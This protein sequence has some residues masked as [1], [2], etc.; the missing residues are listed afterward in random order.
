M[1]L[2]VDAVGVK[3][4]VVAGRPDACVL[5]GEEATTWVAKRAVHVLCW[6]R[7][8]PE[9][10]QRAVATQVPAVAADHPGP[11]VPPAEVTARPPALMPLF[12]E[13]AIPAAIP[14]KSE[15]GVGPAEPPEVQR[16]PVAATSAVEPAVAQADSPARQA[17]SVVDPAAA[18]APLAQLRLPCAPGSRFAASAVVVDA[19]GL[20]LPDG[21]RHDLPQPFSH[22]GH[23]TELVTTLRLGTAVTDRWAEKGQ[24]WLTASAGAMFDLPTELP[25]SGEELRRVLGEASEVSPFVVDAIAQGWSVGGEKAAMTGGW[26]NVKHTSP[27][28][29]EAKALICYLPAID[30]EHAPLLITDDPTPATLARRLQMFAS[31]LGEPWHFSSQTTGFQLAETLRW[32]DRGML[33][34][35]E[36]IPPTSVNIEVDVRWSRTPSEEEAG[37]RYVHG[38]DR[39]SAYLAA[40]G[41]LDFGVFVDEH[42]TYG[43]GAPTHHP[44]G[45]AFDRKVAGLWRV[46]VPE[47]ADLRLPSPFNAGPG[48]ELWFTNATL[49]LA[50]EMDYP[51]EVVEAY[52]W[53]K[54]ARV[55]EKWQERMRDALRAADI[56][57]DRDAA[58]IRKMLKQVYTTVFGTM[59]S[60]IWRRGQMG[61]APERWFLI[62]AKARSNLIR[63]AWKNAQ[64][65]DPATGKQTNRWPVAAFTD[66]LLYVSDDPNPQTAWP[67]DPAKWGRGLGQYKSAGSAL[68]SDQLPYLGVA[69]YAGLNKLAEPE[70]WA[71]QFLPAPWAQAA[72][73]DHEDYR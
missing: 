51:I 67:G 32:K 15:E 17:A 11:A 26:T 49:E 40:L 55:F 44:Q 30:T 25:T 47:V 14:P 34:P 72:I 33:A 8:T 6:R 46:V 19:G 4:D 20:W 16:T 69:P 70:D 2:E 60:D 13:P 66:A 42:G 18:P 24:V 29:A 31:V 59:N 57:G 12:V 39:N 50:G 43:A 23:V 9:S 61:Y 28:R 7:S 3:A 53:P 56:R 63:T 41:G 5:C 37:C 65:V 54:K 1:T 64:L 38:Y 73:Q 10:R 36:R 68:L 52:T 48:Q 58:V 27:D 45:L 21:S 35:S 71:A 22:I 62:V